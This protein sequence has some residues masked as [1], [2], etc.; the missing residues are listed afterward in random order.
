VRARTLLA[1]S[2]R[3]SAAQ[4]RTLP[5]EALQTIVSRIDNSC[6]LRVSEFE[7]NS[8][9]KTAKG[10]SGAGDGNRTRDIL[11]GKQTFYR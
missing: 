3:I 7:R 10:T 4:A 2:V 5:A 6:E 1:V 9:T 8:V 11:L